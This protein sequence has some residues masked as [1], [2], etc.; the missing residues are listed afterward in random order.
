MDNPAVAWA[1]VGDSWIAYLSCAVAYEGRAVGTLDRG[2]FILIRKRDGSV[3]VIGGDL[4]QPRNYIRATEVKAQ[5]DIIIF[6]NKKEKL[7]IQVEKL[8]WKNGITT[9]STNK[10]ELYRTEAQLVEK[11]IKSIDTW[12]PEASKQ[13]ITREYRTPAGPVDVAVQ[14]SHQLHLLEVKRRK[15][16]IK[17]CTQILKY[18]DH[19]ENECHL[20]LVAPEISDNA[21]TYAEKNKITYIQLEWDP[22]PL[23]F[24]GLIDA[25]HQSEDQSDP[26]AS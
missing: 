14:F 25:I 3:S 26:V 15:A 10:V 17:D 18:D 16:T 11:L 20:Y 12:I 8:H 6:S 19:V 4:N 2:D 22:L 5:D 7:I 1:L 24:A 23:G 9:W 21:L 13:E